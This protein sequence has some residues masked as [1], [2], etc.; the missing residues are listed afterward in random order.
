M[1]SA[2]STIRTFTTKVRFLILQHTEM[3]KE[4]AELYSMI[5]ERDKQI[6]ELKQQLADSQK[7]YD[8]MMSAKILTIA[9]AD[10]EQTRKKINKLIRSVN[11]CITLLTEQE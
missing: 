7:K 5:D 1:S 4:N 11:Q 9:D 6:A 10:I 2:E 8:S 3:K